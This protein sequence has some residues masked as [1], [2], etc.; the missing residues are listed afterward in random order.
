M[1]VSS[2]L[3]MHVFTALLPPADAVDYEYY[4]CLGLS[5]SSSFTSFN[6]KQH[7][8]EDIRKAYKK[9]SLELHPD[10]IAQ[11]NGGA[12]ADVAA[13]AAAQ[14]ERVREASTVL[15]DV[16]QRKL[17]HSYH[18]SV[19][20]YNFVASSNMYNP[21]AVMENL[22]QASFLNKTRLVLTVAVLFLLVLLQP[23]LV[24]AKV[25]A[26]LDRTD[27]N[28]TD[29]DNDTDSDSDS[30]LRDTDWI[31]LMI[32]LWIMYGLLVAGIGI[33]ALVVPE[34]TARREL[35]VSFLEQVSLLT[36][37]ILLA[38]QWDRS[39]YDP[40]NHKRNW[41][42]TAVP[43]YVALLWR[44]YGAQCSVASLR[45]DQ[46]RMVSPEHLLVAAAAEQG[47]ST[48][49]DTGTDGAAAAASLDDMTE[50]QR[51]EIAAKYIVVTV[52]TDTVVAAMQA[53]AVEHEETGGAGTGEADVTDEDL[54][55]IRV[56]SSPEFAEAE[57]AIQSLKK[58]TTVLMLYGLSFCA[59]VA[60][61]LEGNIGD[62]SWYLIFTPIFIKLGL[63]IC[64]S[65]LYCCCAGVMGDGG[66][67]DDIVMGVPEY[68]EDED[69]AAAGQDGIREGGEEVNQALGGMKEEAKATPAEE[70]V[71]ASLANFALPEGD[72]KELKE[73]AAK[74]K[75]T[76]NGNLESEPKGP[77]LVH[78][79]Q[80][81]S[82]APDGSGNDKDKGN[83][84][85]D[86]V[87]TDEP[88]I[89]FDE[90][91]YRAWQSAQ[92]KED[93][94]IMQERA[95]AQSTC[96]SATLQLIMVVLIVVKLEE[97]YENLDDADAEEGF[98][99]FWI[100]SPVFFITGV[101]LC[102]CSC[103]IYG[104][105]APKPGDEDLFEVNSEDGGDVDADGLKAS[106]DVHDDPASAA[107]AVDNAAAS[108]APTT[109]DVEAGG[110]ETM[111]DLD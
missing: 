77:A 42:L 28:D 93:D 59:L 47:T 29:N 36:G 4:D 53:F 97:D 110:G 46:A 85:D 107:A 45:K 12:G 7:S 91:T 19:A 65:F 79:L 22:Q 43:F 13:K 88:E 57:S 82:N 61:K 33:L 9:K 87:S 24:A 18:C 10:K 5:S 44:V 58:S 89:E 17:Y 48:G 2:F 105:G 34:P 49:A 86:N 40:N 98:N 1:S 69:A 55:A 14:Y 8:L 80:M 66:S 103:L 39:L 100:L 32:P 102:C 6:N 72:M 96:C 62:A 11:R 30:I 37:L 27:T 78:D 41:Q 92:A 63:D 68:G 50:G 106:Q 23:I 84:D 67:H 26:I 101:L 64:L 108:D 54:E 35:T 109:P 76:A 99:A 83:N 90:E 21:S 56:T 74:D 20:R 104:I 3:F 70:D 38:Q 73:T 94:S 31:I 52:D 51:E 60:S 75:S 81:E 71:K 111:N 95:K 16:K 25:N 15:Q